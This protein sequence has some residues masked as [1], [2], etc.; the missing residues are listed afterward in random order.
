MKLKIY[1]L[2]ILI[3]IS[4]PLLSQSMQDLSYIDSLAAKKTATNGDAVQLF[5]IVSGT[6]STSYAAGLQQLQE[7]GIAKGLE[8]EENNPLKKGTLAL[9][10]ARYLELK[11]SVLFSILKIPRYAVT[12]CIANG[13]MDAEGGASQFLSGGELIEIMNNVA[14]MKGAAQ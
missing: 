12:V 2:I 5:L 1:M 11:G 10:S 14:E 9:M 3:I 8:L 13:I 7:A 4:M 6:P